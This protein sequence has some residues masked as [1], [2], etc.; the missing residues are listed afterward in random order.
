ME[1]APRVELGPKRWQRFVVPS[2][3][4]RMD[5]EVGLEPTRDL[6][7]YSFQRRAGCLLTLLPKNWLPVEVTIPALLVQSQ[8]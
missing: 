8:M 7:I 6:A 5:G 4:A 3:S 2:D 1:R